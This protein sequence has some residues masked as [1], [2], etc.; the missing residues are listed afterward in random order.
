VFG[1]PPREILRI[2]IKILIVLFVSMFLFL[3]VIT[4]AIGGGISEMWSEA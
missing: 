2:V 3:L 1:E 4:T